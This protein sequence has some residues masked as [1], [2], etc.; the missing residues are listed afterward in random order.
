M[1]IKQFQ[2]ELSRGMPSPVYLFY[3]NE[4]FL[5]YDALSGLKSANQ[6]LNA[7]NFDIFDIKSPDDNKSI[8]QIIDI[9]NTLPFLRERRMLV[10]ENV[11]KLT[12]KDVK[13]LEDYL[14]NPSKTSLLVMF[15]NGASPKLFDATV[16][17]SIKNI[18]LMLNER[19]IPLWIKTNAKKRGL[20]ITDRAIEHLIDI[21]GA[22]I[23]LL[24]AEIEK[25]SS[26]NSA[27]VDI[28]DIKEMVCD[29]AEYSAFDLIKALKKKDARDL[30]RILENADKNMEPQMLLGALNWQYARFPGLPGTFKMLHDADVLIKRSHNFVIDD[31]IIKLRS[32]YARHKQLS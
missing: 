12:K 23:G 18:P 6:G 11:Q 10:I 25:L 19:D 31:L 8:D 14:Q 2:Q 5:L 21:V 28:D 17:K 30:F 27:V 7:F 1:S 29:C 32:R 3:S 16:L 22:D 9:L 24:H 15:Y 20:D 13:K 26:F 4:D